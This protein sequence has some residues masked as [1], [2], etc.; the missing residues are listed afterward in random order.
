MHFKEEEPA[1]GHKVFVSEA[2]KRSFLSRQIFPNHSNTKFSV[3]RFQVYRSSSKF[4]DVALGQLLGRWRHNVVTILI[5]FQKH[6][7]YSHWSLV[8]PELAA[9]QMIRNSVLIISRLFCVDCITYYENYVG[10][11]LRALCA[12]E[13]IPTNFKNYSKQNYMQ[14]STLSLLSK[15]EIRSDINP[16]YFNLRLSINYSDENVSSLG[17]ST[18]IS[19]ARFA[20]VGTIE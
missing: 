18:S 10:K 20:H 1:C 7:F 5:F 2:C 16:S 17:R 3:Q 4:D 12:T 14:D 9:I 19:K 6:P 11:T 15:T 8:L 13:L